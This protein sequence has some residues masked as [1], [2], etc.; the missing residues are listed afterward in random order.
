VLSIG[1]AALATA[2]AFVF[3]LIRFGWGSGVFLGLAAG[4]IVLV[5]LV[6]RAR[7]PLQA[8]MDAIEGHVKAQRFDRAIE[9][10]QRAR[11]LGLWQPLLMSQIDEQI[12]VIHYAGLKDPDAARPYLERARH[13]SVQGWT[14]LAA[15]SYRRGQHDEADRILERAAR[16]RPKE[17]LVWATYAWCLLSRGRRAEALHVLARGRDALPTDE[18]LH[19]MQLAVQN[20][21][22]ARM[23][24]FGADWYT[25]ELERMPGATMAPNVAPSHPAL[26]RSRAQARGRTR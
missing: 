14:M 5:S 21:K 26:R 23:R 3:G 17:G 1:L 24:A 11:R 25:L 20:G 8:A 22:P 13:K 4:L 6:R 2:A 12:G 16:R 15:G 10:L 19:R 9:R 7:K 18:R